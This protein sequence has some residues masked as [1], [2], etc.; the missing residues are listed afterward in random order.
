MAEREGDVLSMRRVFTDEPR[1]TATVVP[2]D[3]SMLSRN[4]SIAAPIDESPSMAVGNSQRVHRKIPDSADAWSERFE[5][6]G[7][8][9]VGAGGARL[10][11]AR[12][13]RVRAATTMSSVTSEK[14]SKNRPT[15]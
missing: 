11:A 1:W 7:I 3:I 2:I 13:G 9:R 8:A 6:H 10:Q 15:A 14:S 5:V 12:A 4:S